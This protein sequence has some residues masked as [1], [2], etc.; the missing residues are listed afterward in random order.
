MY[1]FKP[2]LKGIIFD[3]DGVLVNTLDLHFHAWQRLFAELGIAFSRG[4]MDQFR[5]IHQRQILA[6]YASHLSETQ[7][8]DCQRR[9]ANYYRELL[10]AAQ[11]SIVYAPSVQL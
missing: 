11:E 10:A 3:L 5:G 9:K 6:A 4:E 2:D 8:V 7:I 1:D